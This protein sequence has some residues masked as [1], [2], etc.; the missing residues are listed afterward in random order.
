MRGRTALL[1]ALFLITPVARAEDCSGHEPTT[2]QD[3][4][5]GSVKVE[6]ECRSDL[7]RVRTVPCLSASLD[8]KTP[9]YW[10][11]FIRK[12][13]GDWLYLNCHDVH[14]LVD[15]V[16]LKMAQSEHDGESVSTGLIE[17]VSVMLTWPQV[18]AIGR[19]R[20]VEFKLCTDEF[21]WPTFECA[22]RQFWRQVAMERAE[23][24]IL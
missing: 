19:A 11:S 13:H 23:L 10:L 2:T 1:I 17:M 8:S 4:F 5:T 20:R 7:A 22:A 18:E 15:D 14:I 21:T 9:I 16:P 3:R 12:G 6:S 24:G